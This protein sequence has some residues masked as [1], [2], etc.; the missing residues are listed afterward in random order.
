MP[1]IPANDSAIEIR[2]YIRF[3]VGSLKLFALAARAGVLT[4]ASAESA[5]RSLTHLLAGLPPQ[6]SS[7]WRART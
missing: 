6:P 3:T 2:W 5:V 7:V 1:W 4:K